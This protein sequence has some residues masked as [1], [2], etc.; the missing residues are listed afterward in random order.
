MPPEKVRRKGKWLFV[1]DEYFHPAHA[2]LLR[3]F[4]GWN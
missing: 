2:I 4:A 3:M 1:I